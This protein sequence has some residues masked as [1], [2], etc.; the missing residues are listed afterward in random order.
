[1]IKSPPAASTTAVSSTPLRDT[2]KPKPVETKTSDSKPKRSPGKAPDYT[3]VEIELSDDQKREL[4][5][6]YN[7]MAP[8]K[9]NDIVCVVT[10]KVK[11]LSDKDTF[12]VDEV[13]SLLRLIGG[14]KIPRNLTAVFGNIVSEGNGAKDKG[15]FVANFATDDYI[16]HTYKKTETS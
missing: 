6:F 14:I 15:S 1:M 7:E 9:Q 12:T 5:A 4:K 2:T 3:T 10:H 8:K 13:F 16:A 11:Q